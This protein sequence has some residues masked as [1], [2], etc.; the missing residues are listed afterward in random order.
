[1]SIASAA[2]VKVHAMYDMDKRSDSG[3]LPALLAFIYFGADSVS[4]AIAVYL[5]IAQCGMRMTTFA[6]YVGV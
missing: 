4:R 1:M 6:P 3:I 2:T 5:T